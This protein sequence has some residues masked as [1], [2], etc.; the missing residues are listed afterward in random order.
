MT[1]KKKEKKEMKA[2]LCNNYDDEQNQT[3]EKE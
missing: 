1:S 3:G 2:S